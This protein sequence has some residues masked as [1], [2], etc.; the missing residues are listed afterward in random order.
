MIFAERSQE[1]GF[2]GAVGF[3]AIGLALPAAV[4]A[5]LHPAWHGHYL[6]IFV[7]VAP[8]L[9]IIAGA[10]ILLCAVLGHALGR[11]APR[12]KALA[13]LSV[14]AWMWWSTG[15]MLSWGGFEAVAAGRAEQLPSHFVLLLLVLSAWS[16]ICLVAALWWTRA[17]SSPPTPALRTAAEPQR[18]PRI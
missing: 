16:S 4:L 9:P 17:S 18:T 10:G 8:T 5:A 15:R 6:P 12:A 14:S 1:R 7:A 11:V 13:A 3:A 2:A